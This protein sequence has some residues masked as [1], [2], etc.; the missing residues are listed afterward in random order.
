MGLHLIFA[1]SD[2]S[3][4]MTTLYWVMV[5]IGVNMIILAHELGHFV[6]ARWCGVKCEKFY[7]WFDI[8]GWKIC[9]FKWGETEYGLGVLPL[10]GYVKMLGQ[11]DNPARLRE[12]LERAK[13]ARDAGDSP[14]GN[15]QGAAAAPSDAI[16]IE[17]AERALYDPRSYLAQSVP[18]R[19]AII[20]AGVIMN[21]LF[22]LVAGIVAYQFGVR[23]V[24]CAVGAV[25]P[26]TGA[27]QA[28]LKV[29]DRVEQIA[30][31]RVYTFFDLKAAVSLGDTSGGVSMVVRR[32]GVDEPL[33]VTAIARQG[34]LSPEVGIAF[35]RTAT[36][37]EQVPV[38]PGSPA[39]R[40]SSPFQPGDKFTRIDGKPI[41]DY[42]DIHAHLARYPDRPL[43]VTVERELEPAEGQAGGP[44]A[45]TEV[46]IEVAPAPVR[47]L[48]LVMEM[49][50]ITAIQD[51]SPAAETILQPGDLIVG[52]DG[53]PV[54]DPMRLPDQLR[55]Q[56][57]ASENPRVTLTISR[58]GERGP[59][60]V[61]VPL[62]ETEDFD[63]AVSRDSPVSVPALGIAYRVLSRIRDVRPGSPAAAHG[64]PSGQAVVQ[65]KFTPPDKDWLKSRGLDQISREFSLKEETVTLEDGETEWPFVFLLIQQSFPGTRVELELEEGRTATLTPV[66]AADWFHPDRGFLFDVMLVQRRAESFG[67]AMALGF[68]ET[69][70]SLFVIFRTLN[71]LATGQ[72]SPK[73]VI[74]PVGIA[75]AAYH[76][77]AEGPGEFLQFLC[78]ISANLAVINFLP[79]PVLDG[80]HM[81]FLAYEGIRGRPPS[82]G[83]FVALS[84]LGLALI[85]LLMIWVISLDVGWISR[86]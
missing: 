18:R 53:R 20:S 79:I 5:L 60:T 57:E 67:D 84:Y 81:I 23:E 68:E 34:A 30:G 39:A 36:L 65:A 2:P 85:L 50:P 6:V 70:D 75:Q 77:A 7:V 69:V 24:A 82:E 63:S 66:E 86:Q 54:G 47:H 74:G 27:W 12:E 16:D 37:N 78:L 43:E 33:N 8:F 21:V 52:V 41:R 14:E 40:A 59:L 38:F 61:E 26:G 51:N 29:G 10:G 31:K 25:A 55:R 46:T 28:D 44:V 35:P 56:A 19:M 58:K 32:P 73:A 42:G 48:G 49:G 3:W 9:R 72:V 22:A 13:A 15:P 11:E 76:R 1:S 62:R 45:T 80:G 4:A 83:V 71:A 64:L 17:A